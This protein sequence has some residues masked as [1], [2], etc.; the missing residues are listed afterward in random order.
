MKFLTFKIIVAILFLFDIFNISF[1]PK[2]DLFRT[3][4][5]GGN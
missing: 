1:T 4:A 5:A 3:D 2:F